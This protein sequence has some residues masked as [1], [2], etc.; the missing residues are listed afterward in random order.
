M[1]DCYDCPSSGNKLTAHL[2]GQFAAQPRAGARDQHHL[3]PNV[4]VVQEAGG[5]QRS[6]DALQRPQCHFDY[7]L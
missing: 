7:Q 1:I 5:H 2:Y 4:L 3:A 6:V